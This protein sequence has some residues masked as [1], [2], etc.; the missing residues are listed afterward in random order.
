MRVV[1]QKVK[2][3]S[4]TVDEEVVSSIEKGLMILLGISTEDTSEDVTRLVKKVAGLRVFEDFSNPP[5]EQTKWYGKP[6]AKNLAQDSELK[7][8]AVSQFT[9]YG[10]INKGTKPDFHKAAKGDTARPLYEEFL[11][12]LGKELGDENRVKAGVFGAMMEV[13]L[14]N[15]GPTTIIWDTRANSI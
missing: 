12:K 2:R 1:I 6:W 13:A 7:V 10:T 8:L 3:A 15:D 11:Q 14:V 9:L 5:P 4:V